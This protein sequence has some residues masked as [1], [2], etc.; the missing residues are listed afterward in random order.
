MTY[1]N[2]PNYVNETPG[3]KFYCTCGESAK[4]PYCDGSHEILNTGKSPIEF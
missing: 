3:K 4:K 2:Q 1:E